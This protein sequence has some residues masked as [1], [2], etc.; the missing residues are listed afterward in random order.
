MSLFDRPS[1]RRGFTLIE[2]A[3]AT[4]IIG[5]GLVSGIRLFAACTQQNHASNRM[6]IAMLLATNIHEAMIGLSFNDPSTGTTHFGPEAG[7]TLQTWD[8]VDDF[9]GSTFNPPIN[10]QRQS[11]GELGQYSQLVTVWPVLMNNLRTNSNE[12]VPDLPKSSYQG[13]VRVRVR[14]L[15]RALP[16]QTPEE[17]Y[18]TSWIRVDN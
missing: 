14:V 7:E 9:D 16:S 2:A 10:S 12:A 17:V 13:A 1:R 4:A 6:T 15:Y 5:L 18:R 11:L 3:L 8:D